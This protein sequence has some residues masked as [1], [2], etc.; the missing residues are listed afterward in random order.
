MSYERIIGQPGEYKKTYK[1]GKYLWCPNQYTH[2]FL[3]VLAFDMNTGV[4]LRAY[5]VANHLKNIRIK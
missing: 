3:M 5:Y 2:H 1:G 4:K